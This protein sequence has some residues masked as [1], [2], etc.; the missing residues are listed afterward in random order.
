[1]DRINNR[2]DQVPWRAIEFTCT[3][4][5]HLDGN[6]VDVDVFVQGHEIVFN[7]F[8]RWHPYLRVEKRADERGSTWER[9]QD[10]WLKQ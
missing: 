3:A 4:P 2:D 8:F 5:L 6:V 10:P 9:F 7:Y 1:M